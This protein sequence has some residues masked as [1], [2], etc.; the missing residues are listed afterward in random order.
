MANPLPSSLTR[1]P[2]LLLAAGYVVLMAVNGVWAFD[3]PGFLPRFTIL[4]RD[5]GVWDSIRMLFLNLDMGLLSADYIRS[6]YRLYGLS[7]VI[8][9]LVWLVGGGH[10][11][12]Y[13]GVIATTH[14]LM[15][16]GI[17]RLVRRLGF[18]RHQSQ[19]V[20]VAWIVS[21]FAITSVF[22]HWSYSTLPY[23]FVIVCALLM[24]RLHDGGGR[25]VAYGGIVAMSAM[26]AWSG[27][28]HL[29]AAGLILALVSFATPSPR[30]KTERSGDLAV[31]AG[32]MLA[33]I[34][35]HRWAWDMAAPPTTVADRFTFAA[36]TPEALLANT[37]KFLHSIVVGVDAQITPIIVVAGPWL[38]LAAILA[39]AVIWST[40]VPNRHPS[41]AAHTRDFLLP[42]S[43]LAIA[44]ATLVIQWAVAVLAGSLMP[45]LFRRYGFVTYTLVLMAAAAIAAAPAIRRRVTAAPL[46]VNGVIL[47]FWLGLELFCLPRIRTQDDALFRSI[48]AAT[49]HIREPSLVFVTGWENTHDPAYQLGGATPGLRGGLAFPE[50][51]ESP[52]IAYWTTKAF[53]EGVL[54]IKHAAFRAVPV[55]TDTVRL[56][57]SYVEPLSAVVPR[58]SVVLVANPSVSPPSWR[59]GL[60]DVVV[61]PWPNSAESAP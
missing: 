55:D 10:A 41:G 42:I 40:R 22:H 20:T 15:G 48:K 12:V 26:T 45:F 28:A 50:I 27:E 7:K 4:L 61:K 43:L 19:A 1:A 58:R 52:L 16:W 18:D 29:P 37:G 49:A 38:A 6:Q 11:W 53:A 44:V 34:A 33:A 57:D 39:F 23:A 21:P 51:F 14:L 25:T 9:F 56:D 17:F 24:Q 46:I 32:S 54:G 2:L 47:T 31:A 35:F 5:H 13:A 3:D 59:D 36:Q 60:K 8:Q 30:C